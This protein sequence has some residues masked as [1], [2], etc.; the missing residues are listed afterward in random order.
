MQKNTQE[1]VALTSLRGLAAVMVMLHH[2]TM[3]F[4]DDLARWM[5]GNILINSYLFVDLF[6]V[7]SGFVLAYV[8]QGFGEGIS[9]QHYRV[10]LT[11]RFAR[12]FP[13][14]WFTLAVV[15]VL[16]LLSFTFWQQYPTLHAHWQP[17][18]TGEQ[19]IVS[20]IS[21]LF[22]LQTLHWGAFWNVPAWSLSAEFSAYLWLP[23]LILYLRE[24]CVK[25][26]LG[27]VI[28]SLLTLL[29]IEIY[30]GDLGIAFAGW[31]QM[32]RAGADAALGVVAWNCFRF[33][34]LSW[35]GGR[36]LL[37]FL[38]ATLFLLALPV[39][40]VGVMPFFFVLVLIAA[41]NQQAPSRWLHNPACVFIGRISFALYLIHWI[42][43]DSLRQL[44]LA[45]TGAGLGASL[46]LGEEIGVL[47]VLVA[48]CFLLATGLHF[49]VEQPARRY[50]L[51]RLA[52]ST[53][54]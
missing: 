23:L 50:V 43:F 37:L 19:S 6:F 49:A 2:Y 33:N 5:P 1:L 7:L 52:V 26:L 17:P 16:E 22:M 51:S 44:S 15:L 24:F 21:N 45:L 4:T 27:V 35:L 48:V 28:I 3:V 11:A 36:Y 38:A 9:R 34:K 12:I 8:Y 47:A 32:F 31:P 10:Y 14:H 13:L 54:N 30:F 25:R 20:L 18:F 29:A 42:V 41:R 39:P 46:S 53:N 40:A